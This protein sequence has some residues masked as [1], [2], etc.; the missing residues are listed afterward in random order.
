MSPRTI[1]TTLTTHQNILEETMQEIASGLLC[2][3]EAREA[4]HKRTFEA[5]EC[6]A[7]ECKAA[8][9]WTIWA[10]NGKLLRLEEL[11]GDDNDEAPDMPKGYIRN[12]GKIPSFDISVG[13]GMYLL[14]KW[15]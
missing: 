7:E 15:I 10:L 1:A 6:L 8:H 12:K 5:H 9:D 4:T 3:I 2:T 14:A 11:V 13:D